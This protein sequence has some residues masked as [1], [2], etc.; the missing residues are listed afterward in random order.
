[1]ATTYTVTAIPGNHT[2]TGV[3][4][5]ITV[6]GLTEGV[7]YTFTMHATNEG[8][9]GPESRPSI[10]YQCADLVMYT[11]S[12]NAGIIIPD[13]GTATPYPSTIDVVGIPGTLSRLTVT[14]SGILHTCVSDIF[15][16]LVGPTGQ[17]VVLMTDVGGHT[18]TPV[19]ATLIF[20]DASLNDLPYLSGQT[21]TGTY[22]PTSLVATVEF[23]APAPSAPYGAT[24]SGFN[25]TNPNGTWSLYVLDAYAWDEGVMFGWTLSLERLA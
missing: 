19:P 17:S 13:S 21:P 8:G 10:P 3:S 25:G 23:T 4:S 20:D 6:E 2:A 22:R 12:N 1:M 5:P 16:L 7:E 18:A 9:N 14:L 15:V 24:L 11:V